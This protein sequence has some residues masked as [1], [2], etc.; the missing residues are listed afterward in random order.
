MHV[1]Q[2]AG[3]KETGGFKEHGVCTGGG[4]ADAT[5]TSAETARC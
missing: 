1:M 3:A 4:G 5:T 2:L